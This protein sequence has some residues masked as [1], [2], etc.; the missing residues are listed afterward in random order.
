MLN[1]YELIKND[2]WHTFII[3]SHCLVHVFCLYVS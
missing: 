1:A 2:I 3:H